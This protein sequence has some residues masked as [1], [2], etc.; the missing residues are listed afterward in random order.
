MWSTGLL[1]ETGRRAEPEQR[2][3]GRLGTVRG[4]SARVWVRLAPDAIERSEWADPLGYLILLKQSQDPTS[5]HNIRPPGRVLATGVS[6]RLGR[7]PE[8][9]RRAPERVQRAVPALEAAP[10][11][12]PTE[13][14]RFLEERRQTLQRAAQTLSET[15]INA[16]VFERLGRAVREFDTTVVRVFALERTPF[17]D[18]KESLGILQNCIAGLKEQRQMTQRRVQAGNF[19]R[20]GATAGG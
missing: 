4:F 13:G 3:A 14:V 2:G 16:D 17:P 7:A 11:A 12:V 19:C 9:L 20:A 1:V 18:L 5:Y 10:T 6:E 8:S 15:G